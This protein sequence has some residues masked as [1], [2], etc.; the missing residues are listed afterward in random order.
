MKTLAYGDRLSSKERVLRTF[1]YEK[2]DRV[3][4]DYSAN[5]GI[6]KK[7]KDHF[8]IKA[9]DDEGLNKALGIDFRALVL[10]Y[11]GP[12]LHRDIPERN[13]LVDNWGMHRTWVEHGSGGYWDY[14][15][16]PLQKATEE[17]IAAWPM[18]NPDH[19]DYAN[20]KDQCRQHGGYA[21]YVGHAGIG[22]IINQNGMFRGVEQT[23]IDLITDDPAG[24]LLAKRKVDIQ[25]EMIR[26]SLEAADG[27]IDFLSMG[28]DL[29]SQI[30][31]LISME[32]FRKQIRPLHQRFVDL[33]KSFKIPVM[34]HSCGSSSWAY[35]DFIDMGISV[36]DTLQ[37]EAKNMAPAYLKEKFGGRLAFHGCISTAGPV[38]TGTPDETVKYCQQTLDIMM[39]GGGYCF[40]PTHA[41][42]D[43]SPLEN[44]IAMYETAHKHGK[45]ER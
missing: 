1:R 27:G 4:V 44:V 43:N 12:K 39:P 19:F 3:P 26:R 35:E 6:D 30:S 18:P 23:M 45:Y 31:P 28:E 2:T 38:A 16:F 5:P 14:C 20:I 9:N 40:A 7:L 13:V 34:I 41:L 11:T 29:G 25:F 22:D 8:G 17:E 33:A 10:A 15:D 36:V 37:P 24:M 42:Q 21:V 32:L